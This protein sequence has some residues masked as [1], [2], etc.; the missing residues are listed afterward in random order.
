MSFAIQELMH[1]V[2]TAER[3]SRDLLASLRRE[4]DD[5]LRRD[6]RPWN[7][8]LAHRQRTTLELQV[9]LE[10]LLERDNESPTLPMDLKVQLRALLRAAMATSKEL[11]QAW[12]QLL[13]LKTT[14]AICDLAPDDTSGRHQSALAPSLSMDR[15]GKLAASKLN[16]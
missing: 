4:F 10:A 16:H 11:G 9:A 13:T 3:R 12:E 8:R 6:L 15:R 7:H 2:I 5:L 1:A 14:L